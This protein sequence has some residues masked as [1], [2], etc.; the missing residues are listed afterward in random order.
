VFIDFIL[1][2]V[3]VGREPFPH[4]ANVLRQSFL[5]EVVLEVLLL[6][7]VC[8]L[9]KKKKTMLASCSLW[10]LKKSMAVASEV[11]RSSKSADDDA[12]D[13]E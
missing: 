7:R 12:A 1:W 5:I 3:A 6:V 4:G 10:I 11:K 8:H 9:E 2:N 13:N